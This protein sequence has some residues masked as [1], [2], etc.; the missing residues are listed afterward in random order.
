MPRVEAPKPVGAPGSLRGKTV[1]F[2]GE[3]GSQ[4]K[5]ERVTRELAEKLAA[6]AGLVVQATVTKRLL[7]VAD[8]DTQSGKA[9]TAGAWHTDRAR[10]PSTDLRASRILGRVVLLVRWRSS[11]TMANNSG[12]LVTLWRR[13]L[14]RARRISEAFGF[15][16][17]TM[18]PTQERSLP[19]R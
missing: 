13:V 6:E 10:Y 3:M 12:T 11:S 8:P 7:V 5:G 19:P 2:T 1:C 17:S 14:P 18:I 4:L 9:K 16:L 15:S